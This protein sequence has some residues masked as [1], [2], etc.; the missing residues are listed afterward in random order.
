MRDNFGKKA[1]VGNT[2]DWLIALLV[3]VGVGVVFVLL[4]N[5]FSAK[6]IKTY[7]VEPYLY[8]QKIYYGGINY[9][10][11]ITKTRDIGV[12][13]LNKFIDVS[14]GRVGVKLT[15]YNANMNELKIIYQNK[16][17][18]TKIFSFQDTLGPGSGKITILTKPT[19]YFDGKKKF[20]YLKM[21]IGVPNE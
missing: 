18:Y 3:T 7:D 21:E 6:E 20:G 19:F 10:N 13:D 4:V 1:L 8:A 15:L 5:S 16:Q 17:L 12:I 2:I 9:E 11:P 14:E